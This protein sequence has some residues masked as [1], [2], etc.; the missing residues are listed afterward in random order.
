VR[1][2]R[3][4]NTT[5]SQPDFPSPSEKT[6]LRVKTASTKLTETEFRELESFASQRGQRVGKW[7]RHT[8]LNEARGLPNA[9]MSFHIFTELV[10]IQL[11]LMNTLAPLI[12]DERMSAEEL[13]AVFRQVQSL[14]VRKAQE[15]LNKRRNVEERTA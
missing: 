7:I 12:R 5:N 10:G 11:L 13:D 8:L 14:K 2:P 9:G 6:E 4:Q 1:Q 15:L 3:T